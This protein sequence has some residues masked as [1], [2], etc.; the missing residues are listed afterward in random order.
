MGIIKISDLPESTLNEL[1]GNESIL[2]TKDNTSKKLTL[3]T[4][5][6]FTSF[7]LNETVSSIQQEL[8]L[9]VDKVAGKQLSTEDFT[10]E[11][12]TKLESLSNYTLPVASSVELGAIKLNSNMSVDASGVLSINSLDWNSIQN[13]PDT[14]IGYNITDVYSISEVND[15]VNT[16]ANI[17]SPTFTGTPIAATASPGSNTSQLATTA[18]VNNEISNNSS[19]SNVSNSLVRRDSSGNFTANIISA[20]LQGNAST[21][22]SLNS[23]RTFILSGDVSGSISSNL[24]NGFEIITS[25]AD[26]SH[27]HIIE[28]ITGLQTVLDDKVGVFEKATPNGVATLDSNGK[29][30]LSQI[31]D[32]VL[33]QLEYQGVWDFTTL[34]AASE[35]GQYWISNVSGNGYN[36]GDW[37]VWNGVSFDKVDNTDAVSS[38]AGRTGN[39]IL[40]KADVNLSLVDNTSDADKNVLS[41]TKLTTGRNISLSGAVTGSVLFDGS[42]DITIIANMPENSVALGVDTSGDYVSAVSSGNG[43]TVSGIVGEGWIPN[44]AIDSTVVTLTDNQTLTN[45]NLQ[46]GST[47]FVDNIDSTKKMQFDV[48]GVSA[49][50]TRILNIPNVDGTLVTTGDTGTVTSAMILN[51]TITN[52]DISSSAAISDTK[53]ATITTAGKVSNSS[54][55]ATSSNSNNAIVLRDSSGNFTAGVIT[56]SLNGNS[57]TSTKLETPR[58][59]NGVLFDGSADIS[60]PSGYNIVGTEFVT[61]NKRDGYDVYGVEVDVG[62]LPN[63]SIKNISFTFNSAYTYWIDVQNS[64]CTDSTSSYPINYSG[65]IGESISC[66]LDKTNNLIKILTSDDKS[67]F[68]GKVVLL[69]TK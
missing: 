66:Y 37:A 1:S 20:S 30:P 49:S 5:G 56:A 38:V 40:T 68:S 4:L 62:Y 31:A 47:F 44:I 25:V 8:E 10:T 61:G 64:Y 60:I 42:S 21:A 55:T 51:G 9:K 12:K 11:E 48:S 17:N 23:N 7:S 54:T 43:I 34:P 18:F 35:K 26:N 29:V 67:A 28:N 2:I 59:I 22:S 32:S 36:I 39:V 52:T 6:E 3:S 14:I 57:S 27:N 41:A 33:G 19:S 46:D 58:T 53:L 15:I 50:T 65:N 45:K 16:K 13:K 63:A 69:Y 24:L